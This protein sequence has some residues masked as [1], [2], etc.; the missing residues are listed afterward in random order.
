[1]LKFSVLSLATTPYELLYGKTAPPTIEELAWGPKAVWKIWDL[2]LVPRE[3][4]SDARLD[5]TLLS[6]IRLLLW[7]E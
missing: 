2:F 7:L 4:L 5:L 1:M 3:L 6:D